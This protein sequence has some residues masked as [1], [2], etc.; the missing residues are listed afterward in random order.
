[1]ATPFQRPGDF[2]L[3]VAKTGQSLITSFTK[4]ITYRKVQDR[5]LENLYATFSLT[6]TTLTELGTTINKY[7]QDFRIKDEVFH[8]I[9][10]AARYHLERFLVLINEGIS[11]GVWKN[12]GNL[13]GQ[14][15]T[16]EADPWLLITV[17]L[18]GKEQAK[19]FWQS[20]DDTRD[21]LLE[22]N[23][24]VKYIIL[25][26][27]GRTT[28]LN[29]EQSDELKNLTALLP[30]IVYSVEKAEQAKQ[31]EL[32][33]ERERQERVHRVHIPQPP[34]FR[35]ADDASDVTLFAEPKPRGRNVHVGKDNH[36]RNR[37]YDSFRSYTSSVVDIR[38]EPYEIYEEWLLRWNEPIKNPNS[39][40]KFLGIKLTRFYEDAGYWGTDAEFRT[41][42]ELKEQHQ[43]AA[44][45]LSP[46]KHKEMMKKIIQAIP[47]KGGVA[48]DQLLEDRMDAS[49]H[50]D[51]KTIWEVVAVRPKEKHAYSCSK[52]WGKDPKTTDWLVTL[53]GEK[54]NNTGVRRQPYRRADP[55]VRDFDMRGPPRRYRSP[56]RRYYERE[57][58]YSPDV[59]VRR[60]RDPMI[61]HPTHRVMSISPRRAMD[62][63]PDESFRSGGFV[64]GKIP[65]QEEAEKKM[66]E[67]WAA[68][69][70]K[71]TESAE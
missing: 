28:T 62:A 17:S 67:I 27:I 13:G 51:A 68:M 26:N 37:S 10:Q 33:W 48:V 4:F 45:D 18:G 69:T 38:Q 12:D 15:F 24:I 29:Q 57:R 36:T 42:A 7:E 71:V 63:I 64:I 59:H 8:P 56:P 30:H 21:S 43:Y 58:S 14:S 11:S 2:V 3:E 60:G 16:A 65:S 50:E 52:K 46:A 5:R 34:P 44:G 66:D 70:N 54:V 41:Q 22:L 20:L 53:R 40:I 9:C 32:A 19:D 6:T 1:M 31:E 61:I 35:D 25:K 49:N 39:S 47:K 23:D 55:W